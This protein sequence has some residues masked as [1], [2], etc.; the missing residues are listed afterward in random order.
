MIHS[1]SR[2][3]PHEDEIRA[4]D[5]SPESGSQESNAEGAGA[6]G[7][8]DREC[9]ILSRAGRSKGLSVLVRRYSASVYHLMV[10]ILSDREEA[11]DATQ[12]V[13]L[14]VHRS[15]DSFDIERNFR[16]WLYTIAWNFARDRLRRRSTRSIVGRF[17]SRRDDDDGTHPEN[18]VADTNAIGPDE[19]LDAKERQS[20]VRQAL[21]ELDPTYQA[22]I[23]LRDF[24][25]LAYDEIATILDCRLGTVKSRLNRARLRLKDVLLRIDPTF[26]EPGEYDPEHEDR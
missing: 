26:A 2:R 9:V 18:E 21:G 12:E 1:M 5:H 23:L 20:L 14:R 6:A 15:L 13:F 19:S 24:E 4:A 16:S 10:R 3:E 8:S 17:A 22:L 11:E 25:G 7:L